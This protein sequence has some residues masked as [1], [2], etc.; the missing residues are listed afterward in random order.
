[1]DRDLDAMARTMY[2]EARGE[3]VLGQLAVAWVIKNRA[4]KAHGWWGSTP[5]DVCHHKWQFSCWNAFDPNS[6]KL[7]ALPETDKLYLILKDIADK[8]LHGK[9]HDPTDGATHYKVRGTPASWDSAVADQKPV[10]IGRHD[11]YKLEA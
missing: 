9:S 5:Y 11:F 8:V 7:A 10:Q 3:S 1:M 6:S 2:G 4:D